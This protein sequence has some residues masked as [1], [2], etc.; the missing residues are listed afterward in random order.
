MG[1]QGQEESL[2]L[3]ALHH[4]QAD[5]DAPVLWHWCGT[6]GHEEKDVW[7]GCLKHIKWE[8]IKKK[9]KEKKKTMVMLFGM[10]LWRMFVT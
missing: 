6:F 7:S 4:L 10:R 1:G 8:I 5:S 2:L 9:R 3:D